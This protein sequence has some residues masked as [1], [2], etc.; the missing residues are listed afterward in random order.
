MAMIVEKLIV[1]VRCMT[2]NQDSGSN[3]S[4]RKRDLNSP[5]CKQSFLQFLIMFFISLFAST[6][7]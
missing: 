6:S 2:F 5:V 1:I 4:P 7:S 3:Q